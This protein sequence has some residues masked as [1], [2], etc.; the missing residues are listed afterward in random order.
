MRVVDALMI[1]QSKIF[2]D[3]HKA[4]K[5]TDRTIHRYLQTGKKYFGRHKKIVDTSSARTYR[6]RKAALE[7]YAE[8]MLFEAARQRDKRRFRLA[9]LTLEKLQASKIDHEA[10]GAKP[11]FV[12]TAR[13][14]KKS[15]RLSLKD[16]PMDWRD[17]MLAGVTGVHRDW[18]LL[19]SI[20]GLRPDEIANSVD[21]EPH[22]NGVKISVRGSKTRSGFGQPLRVIYSEGLWEAELALGGAQTIT[23]PSANA[24]S[25]YVGRQ[26]QK[27]FPRKKHR[28]SA[29]SYRHQVA[30]DLKASQLSSIEIS[31]I[32]GHAVDQTKKFYGHCRQSRRRVVMQLLAATNQVKVK[33]RLGV[34]SVKNQVR[35]GSSLSP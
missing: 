25:K 34:R 33:A 27:V 16:L 18:L 15:K 17:Q 24:V 12:L 10:S 35:Q 2:M 19:L 11:Q 20:V 8:S 22:L 31:A 26:A 28:V 29:Y 13:A 4:R 21:V 1:E 5:L 14:R 3:R 23:A 9:F 30:A 32:L 6:L 7:Y